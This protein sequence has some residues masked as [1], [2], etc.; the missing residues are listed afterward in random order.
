MFSSRSASSTASGCISLFLGILATVG[1][2]AMLVFVVLNRQTVR[3]GTEAIASGVGSARAAVSAISEGV[4]SSSDLVSSVRTSLQSTAKVMDGTEQTLAQTGTTI[5]RL[6]DLAGAA[7]DDLGRLQGRLGP[8]AG[9]ESFESTI[10]MLARTEETSSTLLVQLD[11]LRQSLQLLKT[12]V[13][14]VA[15]S[16]GALETD[17]FS[18]EAAFGDA[19]E[20][21]QS[22]ESAAE[23]AVRYDLILLLGVAL[24]AVITL[25]GLDLLLLGRAMSKRR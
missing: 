24:G 14:G 21:L 17:L 7:S 2:L 13:M 19:C 4:G 16:V 3:D 25:A 1:G 11:S 6:R 12:D 10:G 9:R 18:T 22:A 20:H 8:L 5:R 23:S 15:T